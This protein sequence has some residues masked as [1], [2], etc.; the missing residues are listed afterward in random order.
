MM[1]AVI[2]AAGY[3]ERLRKGIESLKKEDPERFS[4][5]KDSVEGKAKPMVEIAGKPVV[6]HIVEN[7]ENTSVDEIFIV[8]N[9]LYF[10]QFDEWKRAYDS[11]IPIRLVD[12]NTK[13]NETRLGAV[14]DLILVLKEKDIDDDVLVIAGDNLLKFDLNDMI[15]F[16]EK[17]DATTLMVYPESDLEKIKRSACVSFDEQNLVIGFEEKPSEPKSE[18]IC[19]AIYIYD[20]DTIRLIK[21]MRFDEDKKDLIGNIPLLLYNKIR[22]YVY[23]MHEKIR[24]DLGTIDDLEK[25]NAYF[26]LRADE[27]K[28]R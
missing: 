24:F 22:I 14:N 13:T 11:S 28:G 4:D 10:N 18:W 16:F 17:K 15:S 26:Q 1:K 2:L 12:D 5:I 8:T 19:P 25:A 6:Q 20:H 21:E 27:G 3:G 7:I 23:P 9:H